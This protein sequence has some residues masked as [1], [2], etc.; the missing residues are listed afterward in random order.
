MTVPPLETV[1]LPVPSMPSNSQPPTF[2]TEFNPETLTVPVAPAL[3]PIVAPLLL[4]EAPFST[5]RTPVPEL[6]IVMELPPFVQVVP[7]SVMVRVPLDPGRLPRLI[8]V[9]PVPVPP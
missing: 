5:L 6:P 8:G 2:Q 1:R 3:T 9:N 7:G 4:M